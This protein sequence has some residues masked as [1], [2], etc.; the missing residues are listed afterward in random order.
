MCDMLFDAIAVFFGFNFLRKPTF[1]NVSGLSLVAG[2]T[3]YFL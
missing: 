3:F 2:W 1:K